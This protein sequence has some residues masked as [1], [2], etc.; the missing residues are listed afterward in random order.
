MQH[1]P[2][3]NC[4]MFSKILLSLQHLYLFFLIF[5]GSH[6][7]IVSKQRVK[8]REKTSI[9]QRVSILSLRNLITNPSF[10]QLL[11]HCAIPN[12][13]SVYAELPNS[14]LGTYLENRVN[15]FLKKKDSGAGEV[16]IRVLSSSD[17]IVE[18]KPGLKSR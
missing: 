8:R 15:S 13:N 14:K 11:H 7:N 9:F 12:N 3:H 4:Y 10:C 2:F 16:T 18:V 17:K 6:V 5:P 1:S